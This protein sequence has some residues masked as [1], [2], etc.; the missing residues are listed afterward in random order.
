MALPRLWA[1]GEVQARKAVQV[2][3]RAAVF[4]AALKE[5]ADPRAGGPRAFSRARSTHMISMLG[6]LG[7]RKFIV[8]VFSALAVAL[9]AYFGISEASVITIGGIAA[10]YLLGQGIA[11]GFSGGETSTV[12]AAREDAGG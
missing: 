3:G 7:G 10:S 4:D 6:K 1:A 8:A 12:A 5:H 2:F 11:D 9:N